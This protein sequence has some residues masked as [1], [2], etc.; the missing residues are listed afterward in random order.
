M[1]PRELAEKLQ[2]GTPP[3]LLDVRQP[4]EHAFVALPNSTLIPLGELPARIDEIEDWKDAEVVVYC[5][6]G[7]RSGQ[8]A[9]HLR[10]SGFANVH[11]LSGG[12]ERWSN[13]IDPD[14]PRY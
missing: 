5:H 12:I 7:I 9:A 6:H 3:R 1:T 4:E 11:N 14:L 2:S 8:A 10:A 13:E